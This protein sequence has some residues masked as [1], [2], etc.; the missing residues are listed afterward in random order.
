MPFAFN[1]VLS[2]TPNRAYTDPY[3]TPPGY[4]TA[5]SD[6]ASLT[7]HAQGS[8]LLPAEVRMGCVS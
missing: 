2:I 1:I 4:A 3:K 5:S 6:P 8:N 7:A